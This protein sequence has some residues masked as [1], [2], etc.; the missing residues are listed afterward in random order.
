M[1]H[2]YLLKFKS[3]HMD[4]EASCQ[5]VTWVGVWYVCVCG[6]R[7][8]GWPHVGEVRASG[9]PGSSTL[10]CEACFGEGEGEEGASARASDTG[11]RMRADR[12]HS[13]QPCIIGK[14][15][16]LPHLSWRLQWCPFHWGVQGEVRGFLSGVT[17][18][19]AGRCAC[20]LETGECHGSRAPAASSAVSHAG[21]RHHFTFATRWL[22]PCKETPQ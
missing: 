12:V 5:V 15:A 22:L 9:P 14:P 3:T 7:G 6:A 2:T 17:A 4:S 10:P 19:P 8:R 21:P 13:L 1:K 20:L 18:F 11:D 16:V